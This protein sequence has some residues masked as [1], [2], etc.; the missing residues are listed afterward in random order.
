MYDRRV[1]KQRGMGKKVVAQAQISA[2]PEPED[3]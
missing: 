3:L 1:T 2:T